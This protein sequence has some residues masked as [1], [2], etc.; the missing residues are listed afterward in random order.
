MSPISIRT[1][2]PLQ[3]KLRTS[4]YTHRNGAPPKNAR[5]ASKNPKVEKLFL[6]AT[7]IADIASMAIKSALNCPAHPNLAISP[8]N[9]QNSPIPC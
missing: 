1:T 8:K 5:V 4:R 7:Q 6:H 3:E 9:T 2:F